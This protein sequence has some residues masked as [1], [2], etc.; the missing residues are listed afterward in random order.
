MHLL[1]KTSLASKNDAANR[2]KKLF[3]FLD[4]WRDGG[5]IKSKGM[6]APVKR[7]DNQ[8]ASPLAS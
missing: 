1:S 4:F 2:K 7:L 5:H 3:F 6:L 8:A